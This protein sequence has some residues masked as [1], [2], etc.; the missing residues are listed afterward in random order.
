MFVNDDFVIYICI[1]LFLGRRGVV[2]VLFFLYR[3]FLFRG[4]FCELS[5]RLSNKDIGIVWR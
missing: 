5:F 1:C 3:E 4:K 2:C